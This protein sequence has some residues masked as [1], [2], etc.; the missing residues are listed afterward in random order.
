MI[1]IIVY[2]IYL[3]DNLIKIVVDPNTLHL[4]KI[5][6]VLIFNFVKRNTQRMHRLKWDTSSCSISDVSSNQ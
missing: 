2:S 6:N 4:E 5:H 1:F 3:F